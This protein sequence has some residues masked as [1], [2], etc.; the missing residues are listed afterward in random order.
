M[1]RQKARRLLLLQLGSELIQ[2]PHGSA[3]RVPRVSMLCP[4]Q[5]LHPNDLINHSLGQW[6][7][8]KADGDQGRP[9]GLQPISPQEG[10]LREVVVSD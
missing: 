3:T 1:T 9:G 8:F 6:Q 10:E 7:E 4:G 5:E 2:T